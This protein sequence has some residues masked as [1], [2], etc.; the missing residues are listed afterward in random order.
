[1]LYRGGYANLM[2]S[3][4]GLDDNDRWDLNN[5]RCKYR[6]AKQGLKGPKGQEIDV[7]ILPDNSAVK[8]SSGLLTTQN[9]EE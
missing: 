5:T 9:V 8:F 6:I 2:P 1:M 3:L 7:K 4:K